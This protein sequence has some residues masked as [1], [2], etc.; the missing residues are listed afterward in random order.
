MQI[1]NYWTELLATISASNDLV[2]VLF[3][4]GFLGTLLAVIVSSIWLFRQLRIGWKD[5]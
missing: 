2:Q 1:Y 4:A 3:I 5:K